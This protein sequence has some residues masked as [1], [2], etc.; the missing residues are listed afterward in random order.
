M[1]IF[2]DTLAFQPAFW[3]IVDEAP[4]YDLKGPTLALESGRVLYACNYDLSNIPP[5]CQQLLSQKGIQVSPA[6]V[7]L[8]MSLYGEVWVPMEIVHDILARLRFGGIE[9]DTE[10][11][12]QA[13]IGKLVSEAPAWARLAGSNEQVIVVK[14]ASDGQWLVARADFPEHRFQRLFCVSKSIVLYDHS[15]E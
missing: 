11:R 7:D 8:Y 2:E 5:D 1:F 14:S 3:R 15:M 10:H 12:P 6:E 4:F 9:A 13:A